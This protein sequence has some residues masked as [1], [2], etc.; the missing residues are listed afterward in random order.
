MYERYRVKKGDILIA[1]GGDYDK[2]GRGH[3]WNEEVSGV[4]H[5]NHLFVIRTDSDKLLPEFFNY[6]KSSFI[7]IKFFLGIAQQTTNLATINSTQVKKFPCLY[8]SVERQEELVNYLDKISSYDNFVSK[9]P[10]NV[11]DILKAVLNG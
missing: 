6:M 3:I 7:G 2:V 1:E 8:P 10:L 11:R 4:I 9:K 5:Q